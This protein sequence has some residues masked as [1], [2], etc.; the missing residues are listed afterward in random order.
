MRSTSTS[1]TEIQ[2]EQVMA[3]S[4]PEGLLEVGRCGRPH[5]VRGHITVKLSTDR[6]ERVQPGS[7]LWA[8]QWLTVVTSAI[9]PSAESDRWVVEFE[10]I[11]DRTTAERFVNRVLL[12]E[13]LDDDDAFWVHDLIGAR[14]LDSAGIERGRCSSVIA[15][16]A[17]DLLELDSGALVPVTFITSV[18]ETKSGERVVVVD[19]PPGLFE[20]F[21]GAVTDS[22]TPS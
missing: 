11:D 16:P 13:P 20:I 2:A 7:R 3:V 4:P 14:V 21:D 5:G 12:A 9:V 17:H 10:G 22:E 19:P 6:R 15:N 8:G 18:E 1:S